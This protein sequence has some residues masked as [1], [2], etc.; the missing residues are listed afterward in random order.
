MKLISSPNQIKNEKNTKFD[1]LKSNIEGGDR[2]VRITSKM[3][4]VNN[5]LG[6]LSLFGAIIFVLF[7]RRKCP[8]RKFLEDKISVINQGR[9]RNQ[10]LRRLLLPLLPQRAG[11]KHSRRSLRIVR[12]WFGAKQILYRRNRSPKGPKDKGQNN[13]PK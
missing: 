11:S 6:P 1:Q 4:P 13:G 5:Y 10:L 7:L 9:Y 2:F 8:L 12:C 3:L